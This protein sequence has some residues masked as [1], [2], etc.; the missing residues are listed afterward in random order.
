[1]AEIFHKTNMFN[2]EKARELAKN[3]QIPTLENILEMLER[4]SKAG[5]RGF[6]LKSPLL[7]EIKEELVKL[8]FR[9]DSFPAIQE[10][11]ITW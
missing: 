7:W 1:M 5:E 11:I 4:E 6:K 2:A 3:K 10:Y 9:V 8:G